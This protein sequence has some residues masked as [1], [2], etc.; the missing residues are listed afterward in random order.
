MEYE[1]LK[2]EYELLR[3]TFNI[4]KNYTDVWTFNITSSSDKS[5]EHPTQKPI[6]LISRIIKA[7]SNKGDI[8]LDCFLGSGTTAVAC[9]QLGRKYIGIELSK[10]YCAIA[11][12]R[13]NAVPEKLE[14]WF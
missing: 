7:S 6:K 3:R 2:E 14:K 9:K 11:N 13:L 4:K 5:Y 1:E 10:E 8:V 12:K